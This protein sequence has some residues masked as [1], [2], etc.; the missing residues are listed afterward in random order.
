MKKNWG[1]FPNL[2][3]PHSPK[4]QTFQ[5]PL[6]PEG[7]THQVSFQQRVIKPPTFGLSPFPHHCIRDSHSLVP[8]FLPASPH[9][10]FPITAPPPWTPLS[11]HVDHGQRGKGLVNMCRRPM[12]GLAGLGKSIPPSCNANLQLRA[13]S[14]RIAA[15]VPDPRGMWIRGGLKIPAKSPIECTLVWSARIG[16]ATAMPQPRHA[17]G[18]APDPNPFQCARNWEEGTPEPV[19]GKQGG[20]VA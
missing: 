9:C 14:Q 3:K 15:S 11:C 18:C 2:T 16:T 12:L 7:F 1:H 19:P 5:T 10:L 17:V 4:L 13:T 20:Q 8:L 6:W